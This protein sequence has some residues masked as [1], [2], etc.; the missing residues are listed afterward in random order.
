MTVRGLQAQPQQSLGGTIGQS[1]GQA[2]RLFQ[3]CDRLVV[4]RS[5]QRPVT[6]LDPPFDGSFVQS[7]LREMMG[8]DLRLDLGYCREPIAQGLGNAPVQD[9]SAALKQVLVGR[10]LHQR[11]LEAVDRVRW[12]AAA[13]YKLRVLEL[14]ERVLQ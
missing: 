9:L 3:M 7:S 5:V 4:G 1:V 14:G 13:K 6:R 11:V 8:D 12:I 2:D 10:V